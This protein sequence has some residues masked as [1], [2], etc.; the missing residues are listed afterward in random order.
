[1]AAMTRSVPVASVVLCVSLVACSP[2]STSAAPDT[3]TIGP[4]AAPLGT[5]IPEPPSSTGS[6]ATG[7]DPA[8]SSPD[9]PAPASP[10][11]EL[12]DVHPVSAVALAGKV[13]GRS[14]T[15][16]V[17]WWSVV[18]ACSALAGVD[19]ARQGSSIELTVREGHPGMWSAACIALAVHKATDVALGELEPGR[20]TITAYG[21]ASPLLVTIPD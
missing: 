8:D 1:M 21:W 16:R 15:V 11:S 5:A 19:V 17:E 2:G 7:D 4:S 12:V 14:L 6:P 18:D 3:S 10:V 13:D 9:L 20:Y